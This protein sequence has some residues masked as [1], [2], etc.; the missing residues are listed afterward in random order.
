MKQPRVYAGPYT[1]TLKISDMQ[2]EFGIYNLS[3]TVCNCSVSPNCQSHIHTATKAAPSA[4][5]I[6]FASLLLLLC[7][8]YNWHFV[9]F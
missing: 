3:V 2:G 4:I 7:K 1:I 9:L 8:E 6:V 5:G